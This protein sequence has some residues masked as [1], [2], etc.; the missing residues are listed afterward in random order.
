MRRSRALILL[1][2]LLGAC[3]DD[4]S[5]LS[6]TGPIWGSGAASSLA[7]A[8]SLDVTVDLA[9]AATVSYTLYTSPRSL[10]A[11][12]VRADAAGTG[13]R[14]PIRAGSVPFGR[15]GQR[16]LTIDS[17]PS[18]SAYFVYLAGAPRTGDPAAPDTTLVRSTSGTLRPLQAVASLA[19]PAMASPIGYYRYAPESYYRDTLAPLPLMVFLHGSSEK[20]NGTTEL[21]RVLAHGPPLLIS[22]G[23]RFPFLIVSPQLPTTSGSWPT[24]LVQE[25]ID[26]TRAHFP[27]DS[28]RVYLTGLSMGGYGTWAYTIA[29][30][31]VLAAAVPIAGAGDTSSACRMRDVPVW[32]FHGD[33]DP[34]VNVSGS[35]DMVNAI[36][37]CQPPPTVEPLLTIY[38]GVGHDS[39][40]RTY[41]GS[42]GH[43]IYSWLL[44]YHR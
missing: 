41:D 16:T 38:P 29:H 37:A 13:G 44:Q 22:R 12:D 42:A 1:S 28:T 30:P 10:T 6:D 27:V 19:S 36:K 20:G 14:S 31:T 40:T 39:W 17:L 8:V 32:A 7:G 4:P 15:G 5:G 2:L 23:W 11:D 26:T 24:Q 43:D 34:T 35:I 21:F 25:L 33:A 9:R 3:G 18:D